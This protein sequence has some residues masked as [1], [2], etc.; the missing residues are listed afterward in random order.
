VREGKTFQIP[1]VM[2][3]GKKYGMCTMNDSLTDLVR[4]KTVDARE[5]YIKAVDKQGLLG[6]FKNN[7]IDTSF[8]A[9]L[10]GGA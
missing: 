9:D 4:R 2:Q 10:G 1:S 7:G 6:L 3:T 5:A 8:L